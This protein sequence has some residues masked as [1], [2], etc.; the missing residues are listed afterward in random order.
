MLDAP[1]SIFKVSFEEES[2]INRATYEI[3]SAFWSDFYLK[4][5]PYKHQEEFETLSKHVIFSPPKCFT[6]S[7]VEFALINRLVEYS[8]TLK[9]IE[10]F[11][12]FARYNSFT[13][14][15][16]LS[17]VKQIQV[18]LFEYLLFLEG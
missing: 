3:T 14:L 13:G 6:D 9:A 7:V 8:N 11:E 2:A 5:I 12:D 4:T 17:D 1:S 16:N 10:L 15:I 18:T